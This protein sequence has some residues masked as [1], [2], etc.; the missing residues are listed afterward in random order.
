M[1]IQQQVQLKKFNTFG[2]SATAAYFADISHSADLAEAL[3]F[4][5]QHT[6]PIQILGGGSNILFAN[7]YPGL[8]VHMNCRGIEWLS[9]TGLVRAA[10]GENWHQFVIKCLKK[11][12]YGLENLALIP[13]TMGAAPIQNIGAYGVEL[14]QYFVELEALDMT[15][16][17]RR[18][19]NQTDCEFAYR[20]SIFKHER[21][22]QWVVLSVTLQLSAKPAPNIGYQALR[23]ALPSKQVTPQQVFDTVCQ[24]R[25]AR[26]PDPAQLG[27][28]GSFFKNPIVSRE[29]YDSLQDQYHDIPAYPTGDPERLKLPA[30][31]LLDRAGWKGQKRGRAGVHKDHALVLVNLGTATG[32]EVLSLA[33]EMRESV[34]EKYAIELEPEIRIV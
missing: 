34:L 6:L 24:I 32:D 20:D 9:N 11:G 21:H 27:N 29:K 28:A 15:N 1:Q 10:C 25:R 16:G 14:E 12:F 2:I 5:E 26:L 4:A 33:K 22:R 19:L 18:T 13:G 8:V 3:D 31:W 7:D 17:E 30:A 23:D